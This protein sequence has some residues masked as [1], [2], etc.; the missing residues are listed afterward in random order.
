MDLITQL[1]KTRKGNDAIIVIVDKLTKMSH[2]I[3]TTTTVT[4]TQVAKLFMNEIVRYHG[5]VT[6][7]NCVRSRCKIYLDVL[8]II[9]EIIGYKTKY[10]DSFSS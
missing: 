4:A 1:P 9:V 2:F 3:P 6:L 5:L 7:V 8:E 10:V